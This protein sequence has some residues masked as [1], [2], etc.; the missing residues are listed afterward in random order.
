MTDLRL[1]PDVEALL[2][3]LLNDCPSGPTPPK[4]LASKVPFR[5]IYRISGSAVN[6]QFLDAPHVQ[7]TS[8]AGSYAGAKALAETARVKLFQAWRSQYRN[9]VGGIHRVTEI[10]APFQNRTGSVD[11]VY[12]FD[13]TYQV[14]TRP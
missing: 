14:F 5:S 1:L 2:A 11:G 7:V 6:G 9:D 4:M 12:R 8:W 10:L 3:E 13:A